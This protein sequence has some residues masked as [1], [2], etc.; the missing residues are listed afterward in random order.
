MVPLRKP[1]LCRIRVIEEYF[2][3]SRQ[4]DIYERTII[5]INDF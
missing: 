4:N 3:F 2:K 5:E 1:A